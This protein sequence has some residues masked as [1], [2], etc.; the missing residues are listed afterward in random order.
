MKHIT[1][2]KHPFCQL[3]TCLFQLQCT[4]CL[5][6]GTSL[7]PLSQFTIGGH[8]GSNG[9]T[10]IALSVAKLFYTFPPNSTSPMQPL[11]Q[12]LVHHTVSGMLGNNVYDSINN[13]VPQM[14]GVRQALSHLKVPYGKWFCRYRAPC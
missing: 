10:F 5:Q 2:I 14:Y 4:R 11:N 12:T 9:C 13:G 7:N 8:N 1:I 6:H 3:L